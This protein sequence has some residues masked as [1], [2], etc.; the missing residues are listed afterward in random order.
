MVGRR[1]DCNPSVRSSSDSRNL[2]IQGTGPPGGSVSSRSDPEVVGWG[3]VPAASCGGANPRPAEAG[4]SAQSGKT[5][6][7]CC[8]R[9]SAGRC[10]R[11]TPDMTKP[12]SNT[13]S[14]SWN[15]S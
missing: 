2:G 10:R 11:K 4:S 13:R 12:A 5:I 3:F 6:G 7:S 1:F 15:R 14:G 9:S 8:C